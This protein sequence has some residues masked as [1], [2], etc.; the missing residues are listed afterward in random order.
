LANKSNAKSARGAS[1][2][3][4]VTRS[5]N[6]DL[7]KYPGPGL[8]GPNWDTDR[9]R[10]EAPSPPTTCL[11][12]NVAGSAHLQTRNACCAFTHQWG[13][14]Q[15]PSARYGSKRVKESELLS[16]SVKSPLPPPSAL[17]KV[18]QEAWP[19]P[20]LRQFRVDNTG[21]TNLMLEA[22]HRLMFRF[23]RWKDSAQSLGREVRLLELLGRHLTAPIPRPLLVG[24]MNRPRGWPF[25]VYEKLSGDPLTDISTLGHDRQARLT[26]FLVR[27]FSELARCPAAPLRRIGLPAGNRHAWAERFEA[28]Q[29]RYRDVALAQLPSTLR[30][31]IRALF[32]EFFEVLSNSR[33]RPV[34][35]HSDLW[36]S[37]ILWDKVRD[38]PVGVIDWED[39]RFGDP[40][41]D[42]TTFT[43]IETKFARI[44]VRSRREARDDMFGRRLLFYR[45]ILPLQGLLFAIET[46]RATLARHLMRELR[47]ALELSSL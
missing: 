1:D 44:L 13:K 38:A 15:G 5:R 30:Q 21:W 31:R 18:A 47:A 8:I 43:G 36:P 7:G 28:L 42:I 10:F 41:F 14:A 20:P 17:R 29:R 11:E 46:R 16:Y 23:P 34:L 45:R 25:F 39:A 2:S 26:R 22:D 19:G 27:L 33:Y 9:T 37:H 35:I 3:G 40:A 6:C 4:D 24:T 12:G 32:K